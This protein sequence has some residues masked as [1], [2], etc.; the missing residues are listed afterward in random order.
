MALIG[1]SLRFNNE[2]FELRP[3]SPRLTDTISAIELYTNIDQEDLD[4]LLTQ[5]LEID[6]GIKAYGEEFCQIQTVHEAIKQLATDQYCVDVV[7]DT[8][9]G[10]EPAVTETL[11]Y[12]VMDAIS[13]NEVWLLKKVAT[14]MGMSINDVCAG[15]F[16][17]DECNIVAALAN[18]SMGVSGKLERI[19]QAMIDEDDLVAR[20]SDRLSHSAA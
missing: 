18:L 8:L 14:M 10:D 16:T 5:I 4:A 19:K 20:Y 15:D 6:E 11:D 7:L 17:C 3:I 1:E 2:A 12:R 13:R 9:T